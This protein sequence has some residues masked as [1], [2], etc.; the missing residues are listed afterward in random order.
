MTGWGRGL[1]STT[2]TARRAG[3]GFSRGAGRGGRSWGGGRGRCFGGGK[4]WFGGWPFGRRWFGLGTASLPLSRTDETQ[5]LKDELAAAK[6][7]IAAMEA[8]LQELITG[9]DG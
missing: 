3:L 9:K 2:G 6:E 1:C 8:R 5:L 7:E 4:G